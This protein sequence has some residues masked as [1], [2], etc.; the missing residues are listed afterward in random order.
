MD[1]IE[2]KATEGGSKDNS[3]NLVVISTKFGK[4]ETL[5]DRY[6]EVDKSNKVVQWGENNLL[7]DFFIALSKIKSTKHSAII[8]RKCKMIAGNG[9]QIPESEALKKFIANEKGKENLNKIAKRVANDFEVLNMFALGVRWNIDKSEIA[10][11]DYIPAHKVRKSTVSGVW[12]VSNNWADPKAKGSNTQMKQEFSTTP[13]PEDF[14]TYSDKKKKFELNQIYVVKEMQIASDSYP[15]PNYAAGLNWILADAGISSF[16]L[17]MIKKNFN[18]G[19]H[20][21][22]ATG[23]PEEDERKD[24]KKKFKKE[25]A[26]A[27]GESIVITFSDPEAT[28][29]TTLTPLPSSGNEDIYNETEKRAQENIFI[30][31]EVTNP[32]LFGIRIP[33]E[34]GGGKNQLEESLEIFQAVYIDQRQDTIEEAFNE[35]L[36]TNYPKEEEELKLSVFS[37]D[38]DENE[39]SGNAEGKK[40]AKKLS[41]LQPDI[42][43]AVMSV[44]TIDQKLSIV[45]LA[46]VEKAIKTEADKQR[47]RLS[48]MSPVLATKILEKMSDEQILA[49]AG[50]AK[51][52]EEIKEQSPEQAEQL[53]SQLF[54]MAE[55]FNDTKTEKDD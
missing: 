38:V 7:P 30:V 5:S 18:G 14:Q 49:L 9:F 54:K 31:H 41:K 29:K 33:G 21:D 37:L 46:P 2:I 53:E 25:Y 43:A 55:M 6:F 20:I 8:S 32:A 26:G 27:D 19:Y 44:L 28:N 48:A 51:Q 22:I 36:K 15:T 45:G 3:A 35:I 52:I 13:L 10:A 11:I 39:A 4:E 24:F 34:L 17:G 50:I 47:E 1:E 42:R 16:T 12:K 40:L 23:I